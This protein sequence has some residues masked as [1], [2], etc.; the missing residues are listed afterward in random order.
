[1]SRIDRWWERDTA[2]RDAAY[3]LTTSSSRCALCGLPADHYHAMPR[4]TDR[5][6]EDLV[7]V[8]GLCKP[9]A[10][11]YRVLP[12][13]GTLIT[14]SPWQTAMM[15]LPAA[16]LPT[17]RRV[18]G[19]SRPETP[20]RAAFMALRDEVLKRDRHICQ[21][22]DLHGNLVNRIDPFKPGT[23]ANMVTCCRACLPHA[24]VAR[25]FDSLTAKRCYIRAVRA[26]PEGVTISPSTNGGTSHKRHRKWRKR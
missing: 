25:S 12:E 16:P 13:D 21:Y 11:N 10:A 8:C 24:K 9:T 19:L 17:P 18:T 23:L 7:P 14:V 4:N 22:C 5:P 20:E 15:K 6:F 1:M 3:R 26:I 2:W